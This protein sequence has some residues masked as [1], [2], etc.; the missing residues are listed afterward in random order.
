MDGDIWWQTG[1]PSR[2]GRGN[3]LVAFCRSAPRR[4]A[5]PVGAPCYAHG[6]TPDKA[7]DRSLEAR[8]IPKT[9]RLLEA[10][11]AAGLVGRLGHGAVVDAVRAGLEEVRERVLA[12]GACP[13]AAEVERA[14]LARLEGLAKGSLRRVINATGIVIH[15]NLGR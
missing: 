9:D 13:P 14:L 1:L 4:G 12:G 15:T 10:A 7:A 5:A 2:F 11:D 8:K 6:M 3:K